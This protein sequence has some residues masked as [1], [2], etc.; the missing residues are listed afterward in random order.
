[1]IERLLRDVLPHTH[2]YI[3]NSLR[4]GSPLF[5]VRLES[6]SR[7]QLNCPICPTGLGRNKDGIVGSGSLG[8]EDFRRFVR[9]N[10]EIVVIDLSNWGEPFLNPDLN[11]IIRY[12][13][14][15]GVHL[16]A[17]NGANLN[18][19]SDETIECLVRYQFKAITV[20]LD[21]VTDETYAIYRKGGNFK[22]VIHHIEQIEACKKRYGSPFP[23][24]IWQFVVMGHNQHELDQARSMAR[25]LGMTFRP[26]L[27]WSPIY[28]PVTDEAFI[29]RRTTLG[30]ASRAEYRIK[31]GKPYFIPCYQLWFIPAVN[32][33]GKLLGCCENIWVDFGNVFRLGLKNSLQSERYLNMKK[34]VLGKGKMR[35]D[36]P[37]AY[38]DFYHRYLTQSPLEW[39]DILFEALRTWLP[40]IWNTSDYGLLPN[41]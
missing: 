40:Y 27:N 5:L 2:R 26:M 30:V 22:R 11:E 36:I 38:C 41:K 23:K 24:L 14:E 1:M 20:S 8:A 37:C 13:F 39:K 28:S 3:I 6:S 10:P 33:D 21:G 25:Y 29:R 9:D 12:A 19:L 4:C 32:W 35:S 15:K 18:S 34:V 17:V 31:Y 16:T 7:C